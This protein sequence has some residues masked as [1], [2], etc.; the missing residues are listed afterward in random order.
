MKQ[1]FFLEG[2]AYGVN[3][4]ARLQKQSGKS[5]WQ[6]QALLSFLQWW[7]DNKETK[8]TIKTSGSTGNPKEIVVTKENMKRSALASI[9]FFQLQAEGKVLLALPLQFIGGMMMVVRAVL[10]NMDMYPVNPSLCPLPDPM[11]LMDFAPFT[12]SQMMDMLNAGKKEEIE[13]IKTVL[14]GG[15]AVND[16]M[17]QLLQ[18]LKTQCYSSYAMTETLSHV[19][20]QKL[21]G[22]HSQNAYYPLPGV[23]ISLSKR[24]TALISTPWNNDKTETNDLISI[25]ADGSFHILGRTD[26]AI[27][28][29]GITL[30]PEKLENEWAPYLNVAFV[31]AAVPDM[32]WGEQLVLVTESKIDFHAFLSHAQT[33]VSKI[34]LP[35]M[36]C[37][38][39]IPQTKTG[40]TARKILNEQL[41]QKFPLSDLR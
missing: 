37:V 40:K 26:N 11:P 31:A 19:A 18:P 10:A 20:L 22:N 2:K 1:T 30:L 5:E 13:K 12:P 33:T 27:T 9:A 17:K 15:G 38:L 39:P 16:A 3:E 6:K 23:E 8:K 32:Q 29:G 4:I 14:L 41:K 24:G 7:F 34:H 35:K 36:H 25:N 21:N 28:T